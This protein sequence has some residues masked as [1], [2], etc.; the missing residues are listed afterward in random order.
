MAEQFKGYVDINNC[1]GVYIVFLILSINL[2]VTHIPTD[3]RI[4]EQVILNIF[5]GILNSVLNQ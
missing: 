3:R 2:E 1:S 5:S 4:N